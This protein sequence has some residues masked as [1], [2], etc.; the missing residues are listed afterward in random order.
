MKLIPYVIAIAAS[1]DQTTK[2]LAPTRAV[3]VQKTIELQIA[4][5]DSEIVGMENGIAT[6]SRAYPLNV[7]GLQANLN[8]LAL[9]QREKQQLTDVLAQLFPPVAIT[10]TVS[11]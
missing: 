4:K 8:A 3:E 11:K 7:V 9:K 6:V 10:G 5:L 1:E 2:D